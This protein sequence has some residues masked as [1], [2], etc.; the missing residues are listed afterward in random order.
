MPAVP[1]APSKGRQGKSKDE[2]PEAEAQ[3]QES[4]RAIWI[5][6]SAAYQARYGVQPIR[7]AKVNGQVN[8]LLKRLGAEEAPAVAAY[9]LGIEDAQ[10]KRSYHE[11]GL[12]LAKAEAYRTAWVTNT[13]VTGHSARQGEKT[14]ANVSAA[15]AALKAQR[16]RRVADAH[17]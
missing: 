3:R 10:V 6:Y 9:F 5:S 8:D 1:A 16:E 14:Q 2:T 11:F 4:C 12:L 17:A 7:N 15:Q 13:Q